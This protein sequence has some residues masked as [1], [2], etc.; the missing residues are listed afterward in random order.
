MHPGAAVCGLYFSHPDSHYFMISDLQ[1]D[2]LEDYARRKGM[3]IEDGKMARPLA[4]VLNKM[5]NGTWKGRTQ[6]KRKQSVCPYVFLVDGRGWGG[7]GGGMRRSRFLVPPVWRGF[8]MWSAAWWTGAWCS[9]R[10]K[11]GIS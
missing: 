2:Q 11:N 1:K 3:T 8:T 6:T 5:E 4:R 9:G 10:R 7:Q